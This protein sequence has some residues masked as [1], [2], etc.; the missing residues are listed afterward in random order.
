MLWRLTI[1]CCIKLKILSFE[2]VFFTHDVQLSRTQLSSCVNT[3]GANPVLSNKHNSSAFERHAVVAKWQAIERFHSW[4]SCS[5]KKR[6]LL[7]ITFE[8]YFRIQTGFFNSKYADMK[9]EALEWTEAN[10]N[11]VDQSQTD[12]LVES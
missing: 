3:I 6:V 7:R 9:Q 8:S 12:Q 2:T 10:T 11:G 1:F 5:E 4:S